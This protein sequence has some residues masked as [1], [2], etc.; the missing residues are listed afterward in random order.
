MLLAA[1]DCFSLRSSFLPR[2]FRFRNSRGLSL[3]S[4]RTWT[5]RP[6]ASLITTPDSFQ[7]GRL[8]G[9]YGFMN[10]T[11][12]CCIIFP[13]LVAK[14]R[15][16]II[17]NLCGFCLLKRT[18]KLKCQYRWLNGTFCLNAR[19]LQFGLGSQKELRPGIE[20]NLIESNEI[21]LTSWTSIDT[22]STFSPVWL[23]R[24][25][26]KIKERKICVSVNRR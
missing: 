25:A 10:I 2:S 14:K 5:S 13:S 17:C 16:E 18:V 24:K 6:R 22:L 19:N 11:R 20:R 21:D 8:I 3:N 7:V 15:R 26:K 12:Y 1:P 9:S 23:P 4:H